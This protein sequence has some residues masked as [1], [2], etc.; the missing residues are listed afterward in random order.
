ME[1]YEITLKHLV[2]EQE[3]LFPIEVDEA[4]T[5][6]NIIIRTV[7][8]GQEVII[9]DYGYFSAFQKFRDKMLLLGYGIR[10]N[11]SLYNVVQSNMMC[12]TDKVCLVEIGK[13]AEFKNIVHIWDYAEVSYFPN[14]KQQNDF[15]EKWVNSLNP[16]L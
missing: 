12:A 13:Q 7:V 11:G 16:R 14:T 8:D 4:E 10:C 5:S 9:S 3:I 2:S 15:F 1:M 6:E